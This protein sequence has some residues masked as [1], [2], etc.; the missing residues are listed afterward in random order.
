M[1][2]GPSL[3]SLA[4]LLAS[5][6]CASACPTSVSVAPTEPAA[7]PQT[8]PQPTPSGPRHAR[9]SGTIVLHADPGAS[10]HRLEL[11]PDPTTST[12]R[13]V[14]LLE[15]RDGW[16]RVRTLL[17]R[18][19]MALGL[20][21]GMGVAVLS[22]EGWVEAS[23]VVELAPGSA[24]ASVQPSASQA[25]AEAA[26]PSAP[27]QFGARAGTQVLWPDGRVAGAVIEDHY[28]HFPASNRM[29]ESPEGMRTMWCHER[30]AAP[31]L[32]VLQ[33]WL[34]SSEQ[35]AKDGASVDPRVAVALDQPS[36]HPEQGG[37][38]VRGALDKDIIRRM[39]RAHINE[40]RS[41][42]NDGLL[43]DPALTG[44][45]AIEFVITGD[46]SVGSAFVVE[47]NL[48]DAQ[49]GQCIAKAVQTWRFPKPLGGGN[50][51][52]TYPFN[53]VPG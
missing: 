30:R 22:L 52:V 18:E 44:R 15:A 29:S 48:S 40:V 39:V 38:E 8:E 12:E 35:D 14:E 36:P 7:K 23:F 49:V 3:I 33:G 24:I 5:L 20:D 13:I 2:R 9:M 47:D 28:F 1:C 11:L 27:M 43:K 50:V 41:C 37:G 25:P 17:P 42:Y 32:G 6:L 16:W 45:V 4:I 19:V 46:G 26:A 53:L 10:F 51:I 21:A 31:G 34:C